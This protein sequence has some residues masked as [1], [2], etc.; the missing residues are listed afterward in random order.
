MRANFHENLARETDTKSGSDRAFGLVMA[1]AC[2][3]IAGFGFWAGTS[4]WPFWLGASIAFVTA[5]WL[6]PAVLV[7]LNRLW[8]RLG[9]ALHRV[10]NPLVM[11]LLFFVVITPVGLLMRLCGK[12]PL[13]LEFEREAT[14]YWLRRDESELQPGPMTKQY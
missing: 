6:W 5:A 2:C 13:A 14:S 9:L 8:F 4:R 3:T 11:G 7:P 10:V 1:T 12:R